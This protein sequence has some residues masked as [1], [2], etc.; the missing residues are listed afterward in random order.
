MTIQ[1]ENI[2]P[3]GREMRKYL[4]RFYHWSLRLNE[5]DTRMLVA[6]CQSVQAAWVAGQKNAEEKLTPVDESEHQGQPVLLAPRSG[7]IKNQPAIGHM[8]YGDLD[9]LTKGGKP[10]EPTH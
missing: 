6:F 8:T 4:K 5:T 7:F 10:D 9:D 1:P 2:T 3:A